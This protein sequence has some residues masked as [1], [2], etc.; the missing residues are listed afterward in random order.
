MQNV[1]REGVA[2]ICKNQNIDNK[3]FKQNWP[4]AEFW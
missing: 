1:K 3:R 4:F 2:K